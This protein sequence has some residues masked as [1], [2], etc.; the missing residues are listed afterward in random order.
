MYSIIHYLII[1]SFLMT[2]IYIFVLLTYLILINLI[3]TISLNKHL[4]MTSTIPKISILKM[5]SKL[6]KL[7]NRMNT[8]HWKL[9][10]I[11]IFIYCSWPLFKMV[12]SNQIKFIRYI[13]QT[14]FHRNKDRSE[15]QEFF[16]YKREKK[17]NR[18]LTEINLKVRH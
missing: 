5:M 15:I 8:E 17:A 6:S 1:N 18:T 11:C 4:M 12:A 13:N 14:R 9:L 3:L 16:S 2:L 7:I 10:I